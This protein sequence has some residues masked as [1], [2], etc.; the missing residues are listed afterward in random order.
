MSC[1]F[2]H[3]TDVFAEAGVT[4]TPESKRALDRAVH[5]AAGASYNTCVECW[6]KVKAILR[7]PSKRAILVVALKRAKGARTLS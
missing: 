7:Q 6:S 3:L 5:A 1:H 4:A 2:R